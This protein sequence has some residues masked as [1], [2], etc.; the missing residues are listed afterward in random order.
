MGTSVKCRA[1]GGVENCT[2][3]RCPEKQARMKSFFGT[4][5]LNFKNVEQKTPEQ[6]EVKELIPQVHLNPEPHI[7]QELKTNPETTWQS[8]WLKD[9]QGT[10]VAYLKLRLGQVRDY[11]GTLLYEGP[12]LC[13]VEINPAF[14]GKEAP[15]A[16]FRAIKKSYNVEQIWI[17]ETFSKSG[18]RMVQKLRAHERATGEKTVAFEPYIKE[19]KVKHDP[20]DAYEFVHDWETMTPKYRL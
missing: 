4:Q 20:V 11:Q 15:L 18:F 8:V 6:Q 16:V 19:E 7:S 13:D 14:R 10:P 1:K 17:G 12:Q 2:D 3:P 9:E 5:W